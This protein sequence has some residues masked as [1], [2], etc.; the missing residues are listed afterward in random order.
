MPKSQLSANDL[1]GL[2]HEGA[3]VDRRMFVRGLTIAGAL[4]ALGVSGCVEQPQSNALQFQEPVEPLRPRLRA[5]FSHNGLNTIWNQRGRDTAQF[6]GSLLGIEVVAFDGELNVDKQRRDL[7]TIASQTW[8]FVVIHPLA[9]NAFNEQVLSL[10]RRGIP[11]IDIDTRLADDLDQLGVVTFLESDNVR[12]A[13]Q[14]TLSL[15]EALQSDQFEIVHTQGLL[16]HTGAQ[17]RA[18]GFHNI[19]RRYPKITIINETACNWDIDQVTA[20]WDNLLDQHPNVR[21]GF[22]HNDEMALAALRSIRHAGKQDQIVVGGID[23]MQPACQAIQQGHMVSTA[24]N[25]T[26]RIHGGALWVGYFLATLGDRANVPKFIRID[27][28]I[29]DKESAEGFIWQGDHLLI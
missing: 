1:L 15:I 20:T 5:A 22:F 4:A 17:R 18:R 25:P 12:L 21:A 23:G 7:E 6:L 28:G 3:Q 29:I 14:V 2:L 8:D 10:T 26:G 9:V 16:T 24:L 11:V 19:L 27:G 13:E